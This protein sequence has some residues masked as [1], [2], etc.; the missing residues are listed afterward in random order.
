MSGH[1]SF[2]SDRRGAVIQIFAFALVPLI[3]IAGAAL[4]YSRATSFRATLQRGADAAALAVAKAQGDF[5]ARRQE[6]LAV[7]M[8]EVPELREQGHTKDITPV[9]QN[10]QEAAVRVTV[11]SSTRTT[12]L[13]VIG[14][15]EIPVS[16]EARATSGRNERFDVAFVLDT[17]GSMTGARLA[18]LKSA[19]TAL[20]DDFLAR[21]GE[22]DQIQVSVI[23][24]GQYVNVGMGNRNQPWLDVP[25]DYQT[26][27]TR[28]CRMEREVVRQECTRVHRPA[29]PAQPRTCTN[30]GVSYRCDTPAQPAR[31]E[32]Q[33]TPVYGP[34]MVERCSNSGGN[35]VRWSGCVGSRNYPN[36]T[37]DA[38]YNIRIPG[39]MNTTCGSPILEATNDL[40][41]AKQRINALTTSG[42]TYLPSGLIWGWRAL[43]EHAPL[44]ARES[45]PG[46]PVSRT[47]ILVTDG[48]NTRSPTYP[49]HN[50]SNAAEANA[51]TRTTCRNMAEDTTSG[52]KLY[53]IAFEVTDP[54]V[55]QLLQECS[56]LNGGGFYDAAD[57]A[58]LAEA[59]R[60]IGGQIAKLR[61]A[62]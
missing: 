18:S 2:A 43:S 41:L 37:R 15:R 32:N 50:G 29:V 48:Q 61:L 42:E 3:G 49:F 27:V 38:N 4:D 60:N 8:S 59:L 47:M 6:G 52:I 51:I 10:G 17:T 58:Q 20:I 19:T 22:P 7:L 1:L 16:V 21:R 34:N 26:P 40:Q 35:W 45:Q 11:S 44:A 24:F 39:L 55:K 25:N 36:E 62:H 53:T 28:T 33:C 31:W 56:A 30:D 14:I 54:T 13:N 23:P 5:S 9:L 12:L 46:A 57:A